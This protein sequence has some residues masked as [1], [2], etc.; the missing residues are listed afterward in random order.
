MCF[1]ML[2]W[3]KIINASGRSSLTLKIVYIDMQHRFTIEKCHARFS[4]FSPWFSGSVEQWQSNTELRVDLSRQRGRWSSSEAKPSTN[5]K[6]TDA[7]FCWTLQRFAHSLRY[8]LLHGWRHWTAK[9]PKIRNDSHSTR[10]I[11]VGSVVHN[12]VSSERFNFNEPQIYCVEISE[13]CMQINFFYPAIE[14]C[15]FLMQLKDK[16]MIFN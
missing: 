5:A 1:A 12:R 9:F 6:C 15:K 14:L 2:R 16:R 13:K 10:S 3:D 8:S 11:R 4:R 7:W